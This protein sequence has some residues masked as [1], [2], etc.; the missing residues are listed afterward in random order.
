MSKCVP[1]FVDLGMGGSEYKVNPSDSVVIVRKVSPSCWQ[2]PSGMMSTDPPEDEIVQ[3]YLAEKAER[4]ADRAE[5]KSAASQRAAAT[6]AVMPGQTKKTPPAKA[7]SQVKPLAGRAN[8]H[9]AG[10]THGAAA[11]SSRS[12]SRTSKPT[13]KAKPASKKAS[14]TGLVESEGEGGALSSSSSSTS[15]SDLDSNNSNTQDESESAPPLMSATRKARALPYAIL[16]QAREYEAAVRTSYDGLRDD[17][18]RQHGLPVAPASSATGARITGGRMTSGVHGRKSPRSLNNSEPFTFSTLVKLVLPPEIAELGGDA[19]ADAMLEVETARLDSVGLE[20]TGV[21][22]CLTHVRK[23]Y[24]S[25]NRIRCLDGVQT[26]IHL[27]TLVV[28]DN[29]IDSLADISELGGLTFVSAANNRITMVDVDWFPVHLQ[30]LDLRGNPFMIGNEAEERWVGTLRLLQ[31]RCPALGHVNGF[32]THAEN[33]EDDDATQQHASTQGNGPTEGDEE[34]GEGRSRRGLPREA[35]EMFTQG[36]TGLSGVSRHRD[37]F[38]EDPDEALVGSKVSRLSLP[39][40]EGVTSQ[41]HTVSDDLLRRYQDESR[42]KMAAL[43]AIL[44]RQGGLRD[45]E[46]DS[47]EDAA[48]EADRASLLSSR[49]SSRM[50]HSSHGAHRSRGMVAA[51]FDGSDEKSAAAPAAPSVGPPPLPTTTAATTAA[52][53]AAEEVEREEMAA[54]A[55]EQGAISRELRYAA[56]HQKAVGEGRI[57]D[58]TQAA[59]DQ[60]RNRPRRFLSRQPDGV[61]PPHQ[62]SLRSSNDGGAGVAHAP[63]AAYLAAIARLEAS[64]M[65]TK[66]KHLAEYRGDRPAAAEGATTAAPPAVHQ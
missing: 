21:L 39:V 10:R 58:L 29:F 43:R 24:L 52:N 53:A 51:Q 63:S 26:L 35:D 31:T 65:K 28:D 17:L 22:D 18:R 36:M 6:T 30:S 57:S 46:S 48:D 33:A 59:V 25:S 42:R 47:S 1:F 34:E 45:S 2:H 9:A 11:S 4:R 50:P 14:S 40:V 13:K 16:V 12:S 44:R 27:T 66:G 20:D 37:P 8:A 23:V 41:V 38:L 54:A 62:L 49:N 32:D 61:G 64:V 15:G 3:R 7:V 55:A 5:R 56:G 60:M 19:V